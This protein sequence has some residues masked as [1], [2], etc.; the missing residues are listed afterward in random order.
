MTKHKCVHVLTEAPSY[1]VPIRT[2]PN[3]RLRVSTWHKFKPPDSNVKK[4][5]RKRQKK[6]AFSYSIIGTKYRVGRNKLLQI[7]KIK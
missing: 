6:Y 2:N 3:L 7:A 1:V 4:I 5:Y